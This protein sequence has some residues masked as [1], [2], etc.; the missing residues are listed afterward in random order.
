MNITRSETDSRKGIRL[1]LE[2]IQSREIILKQKNIT[3]KKE[4]IF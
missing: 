3:D 1:K 4:Y 2:Q